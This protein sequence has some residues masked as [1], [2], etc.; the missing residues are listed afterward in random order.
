M[1]NPQH[2][3]MTMREDS[4]QGVYVEGLEERVVYTLREALNVVNKALEN[5]V[6]A[7]TLMVV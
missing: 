2:T 5:R 4:Q 3:N 7:S 1:L 6:M